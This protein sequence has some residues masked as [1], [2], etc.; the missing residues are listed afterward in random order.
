MKLIR[1]PKFLHEVFGTESTIIELTLTLA[2]AILSTILLSIKT[3]SEWQNFGILQIAVILVMAFDISGGL[4]ANFTFSTNNQ[5]KKSRK[6]RL[7]FIAAHIQ[8]LILA[9]V[10]G[11]YYFPCALTWG[12][13]VI[14][15]FIVN[16]FSKH[17]AQR[18]IG[19]TL[20][21]FGIV[22]LILFFYNLPKFLLLILI[23]YLAKVSFCFPVD[24][25]S[26][27]EM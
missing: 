25:Y 1:I 10:L 12:Y 15:A 19:A 5:Y 9:L 2:F 24:H 27:R 8:P 17:P 11:K 3:Y 21:F 6:A 14:S 16:R 23:L 4:I 18:T 22:W 26:Q 7:I 20:M 13:T